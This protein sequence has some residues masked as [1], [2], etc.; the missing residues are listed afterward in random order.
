MYIWESHIHKRFRGRKVKGVC[1][2]SWAKE[3]GEGG[4]NGA[5]G[6]QREEKKFTGQ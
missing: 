6:S 5:V 3:W 2:A 1:K 4:K